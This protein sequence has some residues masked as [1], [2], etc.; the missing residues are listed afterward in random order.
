MLEGWLGWI[1]GRLAVGRQGSRHQARHLWRCMQVQTCGTQPTTLPC[2]SLTTT[3]HHLSSP[4][5][6]QVAVQQ[7]RVPD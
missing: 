4:D 5:L 2:L 6:E 1:L 3:R 7:Q